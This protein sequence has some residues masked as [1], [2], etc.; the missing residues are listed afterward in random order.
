MN[1]LFNFLTGAIVGG[2]VGGGLALLFTPYRGDALRAQVS[3]RLDNVR[4]EI[5]QARLNKR[6]EL[7]T[8]LAVMRAPKPKQEA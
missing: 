7:E 5:N 1:K 6:I 3:N 4:D 8:Q 2:L